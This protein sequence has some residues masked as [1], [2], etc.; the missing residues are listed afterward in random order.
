M[1]ENTETIVRALAV[2]TAT[3]GLNHL[4]RPAGSKV[5][6]LDTSDGLAVKDFLASHDWEEV[7][8][9]ART[10]GVAVGNCRYFRAE[11]AERY[12]GLEGIC[13]LSELR[14]LSP[15]DLANVRVVIG[16]H[17]ELEL[18]VS[19]MYPRVTRVMHLFVGDFTNYPHGEYNP[20]TAGVASWYP[21]RLTA[22]VPLGNAVVKFV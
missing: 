17:G 15:E 13:F 5:G 10:M 20:E 4:A 12:T 22:P 1:N 8:D 2:A 9:E 14:D 18:Q 16:H 19:G 3:F 7:T 6:G 21:G 11:I